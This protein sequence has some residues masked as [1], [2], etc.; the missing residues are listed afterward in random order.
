MFR[1]YT[2]GVIDISAK[3]EHVQPLKIGDKV[4]AVPKSE[5]VEQRN[6]SVILARRQVC[7]DPILE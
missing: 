2:G 5:V 7:Y 6:Y 1:A 3:L 4:N